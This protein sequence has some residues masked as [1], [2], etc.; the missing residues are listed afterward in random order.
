MKQFWDIKRSVASGVMLTL[1]LMSMLT[2][3]FNIQ[4][5]RASGTIYIRADGSIDPS[6]APISTV[7]NVTYTLTGIVTSDADGIVVERDSI[8]VDG[9][10]YAVQGTN[11]T[12][13]KGTDLTG[14][15]NV[16]I[17]NMNIEAFDYGVWLDFSSNNS[18]SGNDITANTD[19]DI[20]LNS[21]LGNSVSGNNIAN[22]YYGIWLQD[23]SANSVY[24]N[25]FVNNTQQAGSVNSTNVWDDGY[26]SG[27]NYWS[28]YTGVD[29]YSGPYQNETGRDGIGDTQYVI[30]EN[31]TDHYPL[32]NPYTPQ[33]DVAIMNVS[34][35]KTVVGL[36]CSLNIS[37]T[38]E[39]QGIY[40]ETFDVTAYYGNGSF[41][42]EQ[43]GVFWSLGDV[44]RN[45]FIDQADVGIINAS[46]GSI[47]GSPRWNPDADLNNDSK[48]DILD[49]SRC[50]AH[51]GYN[52]WKYF[53]NSTF[54]SE[55][56]SV[57]AKMGD[58]NRD[59][60]INTV[61]VNTVAA[62]FG[63][64]V[65]PAPSSV[66]L[67]G[68]GIV[69]I[70]DISICARNLMRYGS[71]WK[72]F[73]PAIGTQKIENLANGDSTTLMSTWNTTNLTYG[74]YTI[75]VVATP[76]TNET[77]TADNNCT[78][79]VTVTIPGDIDGDFKVGLYDITLLAWA[80]GFTPSTPSF[81]SRGWNPNAD[82]ASP[83]NVIGLS[84]LVTLA[85]HY[86][87]TTAS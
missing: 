9:A 37:A 61:D 53:G 56:W 47:P 29:L 39:N 70:V 8:V 20:Y 38:V 60:Y 14:R 25:N 79:W 11:A 10:G 30:D 49:A 80:Y 3:A 59:G 5:V 74:N 34:P 72:Y 21:S 15:N 68:S 31:D 42:A 64:T 87:W 73:L 76:V 24:H 82:I 52:I 17:K 65:P 58:V 1:L 18:V 75:T 7:D 63:Q 6:T 50:A 78:S 13:S 71:I 46:F 57:F 55:Q 43:W 33:P 28:D 84:D 12:Y 54:R 85:L 4:P 35:F 77:N 44:N 66:D 48:V 67:D 51:S 41:T 16:T 83:W 45:G 23:S 69:N 32:M 62:Y 22:T 81:P 40:T 86:G 19:C 36:G 27:G 2:L 26:P